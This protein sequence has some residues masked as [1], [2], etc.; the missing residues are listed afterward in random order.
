MGPLVVDMS[1]VTTITIADA[2]TIVRTV[3]VLNTMTPYYSLKKEGGKK[4]KHITELDKVV[5]I[6]LWVK[7]SPCW[8]SLPGNM[9]RSASVS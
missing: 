7:Y 8:C 2:I 5:L 9:F 1:F 3:S 6:R 4:P